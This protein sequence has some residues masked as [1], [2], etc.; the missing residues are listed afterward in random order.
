MLRIRM[1]RLGR[2]L[3]QWDTGRALGMSQAR[4]SL[5]ERGLIP[6]TREELEALGR[7]LHASPAGLFRPAFPEA[8]KHDELAGIGSPATA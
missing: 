8:K 6:A 1:L 3:S 7:L 2:G 5:L 4:Y